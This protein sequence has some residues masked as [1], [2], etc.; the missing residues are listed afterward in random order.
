MA[1]LQVNEAGRCGRQ[2]TV[3][4]FNGTIQHGVQFILPERSRIA[5]T[6]YGPASGAAIAID[7]LRHG[8]MRVG[9][10]GLGAGTLAAYAKPGDVYRF[11]EINPIVIDIAQYAVSVSE[12]VG[13]ARSRS[14]PATRACRWSV[15]SRSRSMC[16]LWMPSPAI[17]SPCIF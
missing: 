8:P 17:R 4:L 14:S 13:S 16:W 2:R 6:Y 7:K 9:V 1:L 15:R 11:Y 10:V 5:T 3:S 12:R